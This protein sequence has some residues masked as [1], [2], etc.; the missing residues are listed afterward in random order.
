MLTK[1]VNAC[2]S[3]NNPVQYVA[4]RRKKAVNASVF[5]MF[6]FATVPNARDS[7]S[8]SRHAEH[9]AEGGKNSMGHVAGEPSL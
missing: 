5:G 1:D 9:R 8:C 7:S 2:D 6:A 4:G 3:T